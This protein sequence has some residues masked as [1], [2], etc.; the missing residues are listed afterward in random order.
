MKEP[1]LITISV[2]LHMVRGRRPVIREGRA[3]KEAGEEMHDILFK[4]WLD[5]HENIPTSWIFKKLAYYD[6]YRWIYII[7]SNLV[8]SNQRIWTCHR[9]ESQTLR[10][11]CYVQKSPGALLPTSSSWLLWA[12]FF[13]IWLLWAIF[14]NNLDKKF[15]WHIIGSAQY[16]RSY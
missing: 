3:T 6:H 10:S 16:H 8:K 7:Y 5:M 1:L 2:P 11:Y 9:S 14:F 4:N 15:K 13:E 12:I